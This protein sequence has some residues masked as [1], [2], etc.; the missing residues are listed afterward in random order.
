MT[1]FQKSALT[2][3]VDWLATEPTDLSSWAAQGRRVRVMLE[4]A[5][6][7]EKETFAQQLMRRSWEAHRAALAEP[8][9][10]VKDSLQVDAARELIDAKTCRYPSCVDDSGRC[11]RLFAGE[12]SG[13]GGVVA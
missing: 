6:A 7:E 8:E 5:L 3:A 10:T 11:A 2:I 4:A 12:C 13:P 9:P 1:P